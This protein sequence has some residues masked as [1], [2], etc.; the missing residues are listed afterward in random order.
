[1][2]FLP[3]TRFIPK[4]LILS[5]VLSSLSCGYQ[6]LISYHSSVEV[7]SIRTRVPYPDLAS[8]VTKQ[9]RKE[10]SSRTKVSSKADFV[11]KG[12]IINSD[13][14]VGMIVRDGKKLRSAEQRNSI[15]LRAEIT[16]RSDEILW[17]PTVYREESQMV[18]GTSALD[19]RSSFHHGKARMC[20]ALTRRLID[21]VSLFLIEQR[22]QTD[23][24][25]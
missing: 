1:M 15:A 21:D 18:E 4:I 13:Q 11:L 25:D 19:T 20:Q 12:E 10:L 24:V 7:H 8:C 17:G 22:A 9:L 16:D 5:L 2:S 6:S 3:I 23:D 14:S